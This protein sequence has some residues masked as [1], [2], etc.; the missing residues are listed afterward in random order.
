MHITAAQER[1]GELVDV[2]C[3]F[4]RFSLIFLLSRFLTQNG[5]ENATTHHFGI[6]GL[7]ILM[8]Y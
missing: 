2:L 8:G 4:Q 1:D 6:H 7:F 3:K 5:K